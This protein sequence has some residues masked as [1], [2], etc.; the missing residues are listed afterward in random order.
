M[1][2]QVNSTETTEKACVSTEFPEYDVQ[3]ARC[4]YVFV[5]KTKDYGASWRVMRVSSLIDQILIK[6][7]RIRSIEEK[8]GVQK[9]SDSVESEYVGIANYSVMTLIQLNSDSCCAPESGR[10]KLSD[11]DVTG[12][13]GSEEIHQPL[14]DSFM[15]E[16]R[17]LMEKKNHDYGD[18]WKEMWISSLTDLILCKILRIRQIMKNDGKTLV[19][20]GIEANLYDMINY[21]LFAL[22]RLS[23]K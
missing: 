19:S 15:K 4:R 2:N 3:A 17:T 14:F 20:E 5:T 7:L 8:G 12:E 1:E 18:A 13:P 10:A 11:P 22:I 23:E 6:V 9:I 21:S 16:A